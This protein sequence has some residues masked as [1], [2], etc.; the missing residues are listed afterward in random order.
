MSNSI[1]TRDDG[2]PFALDK[3]GTIPKFIIENDEEGV[4][5]LVNQFTL[6]YEVIGERPIRQ[7]DPRL[8]AASKRLF[9][10]GQVSDT[11]TPR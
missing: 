4:A 8:I 2:K 9:S 7:D 3:R 11:K 1:P 10:R 6:D 5:I